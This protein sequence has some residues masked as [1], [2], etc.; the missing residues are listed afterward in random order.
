MSTSANQYF[1]YGIL[2]P[3]MWHK[4]WEAKTGKEFYVTFE[5]YIEDKAYE[6][7]TRHKDGIFCLFDGR[8]GKFIIIGRVLKKSS[9]NDPFLGNDKPLK[10]PILE[11]YEKI[12]IE[13]AVY[14]HF[15]LDGEFNYYFVT[16][17]R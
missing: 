3:F 2:V 11:D 9:A 5:K 10:V 17:Y 14:R 4:E 1:M 13:D 12:I 15:D 6:E 8:D 16:R 7:L